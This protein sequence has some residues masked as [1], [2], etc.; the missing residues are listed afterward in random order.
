MIIWVCEKNSILSD[1]ISSLENLLN[2]VS[3]PFIVTNKEEIIVGVSESWLKMCDYEIED[4]IGKTPK[5]IQGVL[6]D[7][8]LTRIFS[9][10]I[11]NYKSSFVSVINY[12]K[13]NTPFI[14]H[15]FGYSFGDLFIVET[16]AKG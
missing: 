13:K 15:I 2:N 11:K 7:K 14:N 3:N 9:S 5:L 16:Y 12:T 8:R 10:K 6:T 1:D 4:V